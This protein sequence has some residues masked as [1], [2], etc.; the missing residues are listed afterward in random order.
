M[1]LH[2]SV[3][4]WFCAFHWHKV[5]HHLW[6]ILVCGTHERSACKSFIYAQGFFQEVY[7]HVA[8]ES[9]WSH[10]SPLLWGSPPALWDLQQCVSLHCLFPHS[11]QRNKKWGICLLLKIQRDFSDFRLRPTG[12][13]SLLQVCYVSCGV[14]TASIQARNSAGLP[15][16]A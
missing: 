4:S 10:C 7:L 16:I 13:K 5:G 9:E 11:Q 15:H 6:Q 1:G 14:L 3:L 2:F 8:T 12:R